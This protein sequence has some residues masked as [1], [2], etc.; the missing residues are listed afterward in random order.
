VKV[1][2]VFENERFLAVDK[3]AGWLTIPGRQGQEDE[4]PCLA[5]EL[6][7]E[8]RCLLVVHRLDVEASG[9]VLFAKDADAHRVANGWFESREVHK[10]YEA[11]TEGDA[12]AAERLVAKSAPLVWRSRLL[13]GKKRAH[14]SPVGKAAMTHAWYEGTNEL[15]S[16]PILRWR[17]S[18]LTGRA[19][20]LR[21]ELAKRGFPI[22]GDALY[23]AKREFTEGAIALRAVKLD[24]RDC[25]EASALGLPAHLQVCGLADA[26][27][28]AARDATESGT[29]GRK[30]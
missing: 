14:E 2:I 9:L 30:T 21:Y 1:V 3:P 25:P 5:S 8:R 10:T 13:R 7:Q 11:W 4:R 16:S 17:L 23:G 28:T 29:E 22:L 27:G 26:F 6:R 20:Q 18:P 19:H 12:G 15:G 24:F